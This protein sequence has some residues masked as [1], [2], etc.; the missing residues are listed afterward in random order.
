MTGQEANWVQTMPGKST[1]L[2]LARHRWRS[3]ARFLAAANLQTEGQ[4]FNPLNRHHV[5]NDLAC[6]GGGWRAA[7][8]NPWGNQKQKGTPLLRYRSADWL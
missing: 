4:E 7:W 6:H 8:G 2:V 5:F 3:E 1:R